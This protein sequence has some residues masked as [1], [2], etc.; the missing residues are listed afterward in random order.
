MDRRAWITLLVVVAGTTAGRLW[1]ASALPLVDDEAYYWAWA[2]RPAWG[3]PDHPPAVAGMIGVTTALLG[4]TPLGVRF[5]AVLLA[6][7]TTALVFAL[8]RMMFGAS[9]GLVAAIGFQLIPSFTLG[10]LFAFPDAPFIFFWI[11]TLWALWRA[12]SA[13]RPLD[14][15]LTGLGAGLAMLSKMT[16]V[17]LLIS[18]AG[19][20][21]GA[22]SERRW[23]RRPEP[24]LAAAIA[25]LVLLPFLSWNATHHWATFQR[26]RAP[27]AWIRTDLP[28][29]SAAAFLAAQLAYYGPVTA[30]L[31]VAALA[32]SAVPRRRDPR[33][34]FL[35]WSALPLM[36]VTWAASFDGIPK[37]HW[38]AP[39]FLVAL[40]AA[41][42]LWAEVRT[43]RP[44]RI[45]AGAAAAVNLAAVAALAALPF[46]PDYAGA[47]QLWG[48]DQL[49]AR[50][51]PLME[52]TPERPGRFVMTAAYQTAGQIEY[53]LRRRYTVA[54]PNEGGDAYD[55]WV[56]AQ[57][58]IDRNAVYLNDLRAPPGVPLARMFRTVER[59]PDIEVVLHGRVV[60]R[61]AVYR[62][63]GF[64]GVP[65]PAAVPR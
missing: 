54:T 59:L 55:L 49:A 5:G 58:L 18:V 2:Q 8:G 37:P 19:F 64:R 65:R 34:L 38:H 53:H 25:L 36:G 16:A 22:P 62:G 32:A 24:Y 48:W 27:L 45:T 40:I 14:W 1:L 61:F 21:L 13:G 30:P 46:R 44:W 33:H 57:H 52:A 3:Y 31:L 23:F 39:G 11:L 29:L 9:A 6:A 26:A 41:G 7:G 43:R 50:L 47:G 28:A 12:R 51:Q 60:R 42:A 4:D 20:L 35:L 56:P 10:S 15:V 17:F 63:L